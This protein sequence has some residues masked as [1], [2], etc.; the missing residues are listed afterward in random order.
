[1]GSSGVVRAQ[2]AAVEILVPNFTWDS[3]GSWGIPIGSAT[4]AFI[5]STGT[6]A[7]GSA[8][9]VDA[10]THRLTDGGS[11]VAGVWF[12]QP[13]TV[14]ASG[15]RIKFNFTLSGEA[16][17]FAVA[18]LSTA[19]YPT[20]PALGS[21]GGNLGM[22]NGA[23]LYLEFRTWDSDGLWLTPYGQNMHNGS[24]LYSSTW[25]GT[26][27]LDVSISTGGAVDVLL[28]GASILSVAGV[29]IPTEAWVGIIAATGGATQTVTVSGGEIS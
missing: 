16:D 29:A 19:S 5:G 23:G 14:A 11:Q 25:T 12:D 10:V 2:R 17:G 22:I 20:E 18:L 15:V 3:L 1:M 26:H 4:K 24:K 28:D 8:T 27:S 9:L 7:Q 13:V 6:I 21:N